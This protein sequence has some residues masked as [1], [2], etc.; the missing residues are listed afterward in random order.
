MTTIIFGVLPVAVILLPLAGLAYWR[1]HEKKRL[2]RKAWELV[3]QG[4]VIIDCVDARAKAGA[5]D[6]LSDALERKWT[7]NSPHFA[8]EKQET[9]PQPEDGRS[10][11]DTLKEKIEGLPRLFTD[12]YEAQAILCALY[13]SRFRRFDFGNQTHRKLKLL[14]SPLWFLLPKH[15]GSEMRGN[16]FGCDQSW[17]IV[18]W[19]NRSGKQA[20]RPIPFNAHF[21]GGHNNAYT[22]LGIP[23]SG[24]DFRKLGSMDE[25][26]LSMPIWQTAILFYCDTPGTL[27]AREGATGFYSLSHFVVAEA[28]RWTLLRGNAL[29]TIDFRQA[30]KKWGAHSIE[31]LVQPHLPEGK[32]IL[33]IGTLAH[34]RMWCTEPMSAQRPRVIQ[35]C[36]VHADYKYLTKFEERKTFISHIPRESLLA[37]LFTSP[38]EL[39]SQLYGADDTETNRYVRD[40]ARALA[41]LINAG[42]GRHVDN[43][44]AAT[45]EMESNSR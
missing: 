6:R 13:D 40:A 43:E 45:A 25:I 27:G 5:W 7:D 15:F 9:W 32:G 42:E 37:R 31:R 3:K 33:A 4:Y 36:K 24:A 8:L 29:S 19:P 44:D 26:M 28:I 18:N 39:C 41:G 1:N 38:L 23:C 2:N 17:H 20:G 22:Q 14:M 35:N 21:D 11:N 10:S 30:L 34:T 12:N 16:L